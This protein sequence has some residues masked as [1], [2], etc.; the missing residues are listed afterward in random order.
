MNSNQPSPAEL[1]KASLIIRFAAIGAVLAGIV[2]LFAYAG[3]WL[4][5]H[6]LSPT[7][8]IDT[9][10]QVNGPHSGFRRNH[11]KGVCVGGFFESNG[12]G[13]RCRKPAIFHPVRVPVIGRFALAGGQ[14]FI[15]DAPNTVRS[16]A[17]LFKLPN[18]EE[19][20]TGMNNIPV[21]PVKTAEGF[22]DQLVGFG[23]GPGDRQARPGQNEG[24]PG[25]PS[26]DRQGHAVDRQ[27]SDLVRIR[28]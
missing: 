18:G 10:E 8:M 20:R 19:W 27:T 11:A 23:P 15:T 14:P 26:G 22:R 28:E 21:F 4:T 16:M 7:S 2:G 13:S 6:T 12:R 24:L 17:I 25:R 9:F 5:P 1:S 3:G